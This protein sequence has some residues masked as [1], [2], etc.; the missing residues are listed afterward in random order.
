MPIPPFLAVI[1]DFQAH[2]VGIGEENGAIIGGVFG[3]EPGLGRRD[4]RRDQPRRRV[5]D[6]V[7]AVDPEAQMVQARAMGVVR[8]AFGGAD[9]EA[10]MAVEYWICRSRP[11]SNTLLRKPSAGMALS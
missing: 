1:G 3:I 4:P 7:G 5:G 9:N 8:A 10:E 11:S 6:I 2:A